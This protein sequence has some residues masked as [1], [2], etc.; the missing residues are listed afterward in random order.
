MQELLKTFFLTRRDIQEALVKNDLKYCYDVIETLISQNTDIPKALVSAFTLIL[1]ESGIDPLSCL[2]KIYPHMYSGIDYIDEVIIPS[3][4]KSIGDWAF[5]NC[6]G[7][8]SITI[9]DSVTSIG[10]GAIYACTSLTNIDIP[11]SVTS[12]GASAFRRCEGLTNIIIP[13][14]VKAIKVGAFYGCK[15]LKSVEIPDSVRIIGYTVF[16]ECP[17]L[18]DVTIPKRFMSSLNEIFGEHQLE[19]NFNFI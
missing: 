4:I 6:S 15:K 5:Y 19:I 1:I 18:K 16:E 9:P 12:I 3:N 7:L 10:Y 14:G 11:N 13:D 2:D 8:K 17:K